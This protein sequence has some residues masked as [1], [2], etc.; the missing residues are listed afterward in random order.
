MGASCL[1][2]AELLTVAMDHGQF[3]L[4]TGFWDGLDV[5]STVHRAIAGDGIAQDGPLLVVLSPHQNNFAMSL[6]SERWTDEPPNDL[7]DWQEAFHASLDVDDFGL[8]WM[9]TT[10][11]EAT[12]EAPPGQ[13]VIRIAGRG[14]VQRGWPGSTTP[15]DVWRL[16]LWPCVRGPKPARLKSWTN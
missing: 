6:R 16:Q 8:H 3:Y 15:G 1:E 7:A 2:H 13:Y 10:V 14:F 9:S 12:L 4:C 11:G 5:V